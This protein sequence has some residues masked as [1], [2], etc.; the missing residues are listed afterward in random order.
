MRFK[1]N[2]DN[3][4]KLV[5]NPKM[6]ITSFKIDYARNNEN[7][8]KDNNI[9]NSINTDINNSNNNDATIMVDSD[10]N[11]NNNYNSKNNIGTYDCVRV[12]W[13]F[14]SKL[15]L[16]WR[17][18]LAAAG[19]TFHFLDPQSGLIIRYEESWKSKPW[20]VV[21]RIFIPTKNN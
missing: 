12:G 20:D 17:P 11:I 19:E 1:K 13:V 15:A 7:E 5:L 2:A 16:P 9:I 6:R 8:N 14:N 18:I 4:G 3:L 10:I 21:K